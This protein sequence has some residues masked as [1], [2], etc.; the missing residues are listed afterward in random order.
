[1]KVYTYNDKV[2]TNSA[3]GMWL[4]KYVDPYNPLGL[5][6][7]T[8]RFK[9][10]HGETPS[11]YFPADIYTLT[12]IS[13]DPTGDIYDW[14][15]PAQICGGD[16]SQASAYIKSNLLAVLG[17]NSN[18]YTGSASSVNSLNSL[19]NG[20]TN[21][22]EVG[23]LYTP[24]IT[25]FSAMFV[26][27]S[28]LTAVPLLNISNAANV[29]NM[30]KGCVSVQSGALAMYNQLSALGAQITNY[31]DCFTD[32]GSNTVTGAAELAQ[33]PSAWGGTGA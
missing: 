1:M 23:P 9:Y 17:V 31:T 2:L 12:L 21:L 10:T 32:C 7:A 20:C 15:C 11:W 28:A 22:T 5:P 6:D 14:T 19:F 33:I 13:E 26:N 4:K 16:F 27:C 3:N 8:I 29:A 18:G 24:G 30:F 25:D